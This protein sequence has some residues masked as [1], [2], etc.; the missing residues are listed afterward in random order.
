MGGPSVNLFSQPFATRRTVYGFIDRQNLPGVMRTFDFAAPD[1]SSAQRHQTTVPQ[2]SLFL[3]NSPFMKEQVRR[4]AARPDVLRHTRVEQRIDAV[5]RLLYGRGPEPGEVTLGA[6]FLDA[7][8]A[9]A[10]GRLTAW[11]EYVQVLLLANEFAFV[12]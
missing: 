6:K 11:E 10:P 9:P 3:M 8:S 5:Y 2:Q 7:A 1:A 12:D 4:L